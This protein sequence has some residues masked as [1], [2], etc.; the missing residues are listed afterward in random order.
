LL[1]RTGAA[2]WRAFDCRQAGRDRSTSPPRLL[3][4]VGPRGRGQSPSMPITRP[5][6][7]NAARR[8]VRA[9][10]PCR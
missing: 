9:G 5:G 2:N 7:R 8:A 6:R 10:W 4:H 3:C 1:A